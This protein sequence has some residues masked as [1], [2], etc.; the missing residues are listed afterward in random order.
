MLAAVVITAAIGLIDVTAVRRLYRVRRSEFILWLAAFLGV[1]L[2][3]VLPGIF[4]AILLSLGDFVRRAWR[5]HDAVLGRVDELKGYH[6][7]ARHPNA[8]RIPAL[9]LYRFDAPLFFANAGYFR[10]RVRRLIA[11]A[12]HPVRWVVVAAEPITD[13]DSTAADTLFQL[14]EELRQRGVTLAFAECKDPVKDRLQRYGLIAAIGP[15]LFFPA[16]GDERPWGGEGGQLAGG[17]PAGGRVQADGVRG[18]EV[19]VLVAVQLG[20][21]MLLDGVLDRQRM[22]PELL[23]DDLQV[24][25][26]GL[27]QVQPHHR[28]GLL[29]VVGDLSGREVLG[30]QHPLAVQPGMA[31]T[32]SLSPRRRDRGASTGR[33]LARE[34]RSPSLGSELTVCASECGI[35]P[36]WSP[37]AVA[38]SLRPAVGL[39]DCRLS[40]LINLKFQLLRRLQCPDRGH[41]LLRHMHC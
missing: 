17:E 23:R 29:E 31:H 25:M 21:L 34:T 6:D 1:A 19:V 7:T 8:R 18:E 32:S 3:G 24:G 36:T 41:R 39:P 33:T 26:V 38:S 27:A 35:T 16:D 5:P 9:L 2:L 40:R 4:G 20:P 13:V 15:D 22:Q 30:L 10:R 14:L 11:E 12:T 28:A 37:L